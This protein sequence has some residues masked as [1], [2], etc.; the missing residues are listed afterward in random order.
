MADDIKTLGASFRPLGDKATWTSR[1][2]KLSVDIYFE[3]PAQLLNKVYALNQLEGHLAVGTDVDLF[4]A[5]NEINSN[6][7]LREEPCG[8][9][10]SHD[11]RVRVRTDDDDNNYFEK[12]CQNC[13]AKLAFGCNKKGGGLFG[14]RFTEDKQRKP[15]NGWM[16]YDKSLGKE[17]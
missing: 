10:G 5:L 2:G 3:N 13:Y 9:C 1:D 6:D 11:I 14:K 12:T 8:K 15:D 4:K 17:V 16:R 7:V